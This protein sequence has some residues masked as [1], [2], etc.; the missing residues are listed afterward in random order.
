MINI[1]KL[2]K[3]SHISKRMYIIKNLSE[4]M[5]FDIEYLFSLL[6]MFNAKNSGRWFWQKAN[7]T[8]VL[9][10]SFDKFNI[11]IDKL[12]REIK[13]YNDEILISKIENLKPLL[14]ELIIK[15]E[16]SLNVEHDQD[17]SAVYSYMDLNL[18][19]LIKDSLKNMD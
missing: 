9:K 19:Q 8:G 13:N 2:R 15:L 7:F 6:N 10:D 16:T 1:E 5:G 4:D 12:I 17:H 11:N 14:E 3:A 18:K